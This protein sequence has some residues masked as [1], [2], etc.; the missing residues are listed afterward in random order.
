[1]TTRTYACLSVRQPFASLIVHG[2]KLLENREW[3]C[4]YKGR[5][6]IHAGK[7][8]GRDEED[9]YQDLMQVA[10][11]HGD[12]A[13]QKVLFMSRSM[14][15]GYVGMVDMVGCVDSEAWRRRGGEPYDGWQNWFVGPYAFE[16]VRPRAFSR[17]IRFKGRQGIFRVPAWELTGSEEVGR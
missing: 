7:T 14:L 8:W 10:I 6:V 2:I 13:R 3:P 1:M 4:R 15:G 12:A 11:D 5:L 9:A 16:L 17:L